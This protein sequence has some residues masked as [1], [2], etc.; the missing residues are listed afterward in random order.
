[1]GRKTRL[2][3]VS[4][5]VN[6]SKKVIKEL[7]IKIIFSRGRGLRIMPHVIAAHTTDQC[8][9][10]FGIRDIPQV[11]NKSPKAILSKGKN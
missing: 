9:W 1:M 8:S 5:F 2:E 11:T 4:G 7:M 10:N 6:N 3:G